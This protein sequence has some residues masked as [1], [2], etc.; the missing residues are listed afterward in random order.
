M[1]YC[2]QMERSFTSN[3]ST[4][5]ALRLGIAVPFL[6]FGIQLIAAPFFAGY[7]FLAMAASLLGSERSSLP[8]VF[9]L[10]AMLTGVAGL[11]CAIGLILAFR[12]TK[13]PAVLAWL[14]SIAVFLCGLSS[15]WAGVFP[16]PDPRH[17]ENPF[18]IGLF[19]MPF[20]ALAT[21]WRQS[22]R[23]YFLA[24]VLLFLGLIPFM[25]G[26]IAIDRSALEGLLQRLLALSAFAP[27]GLAAHQ[28]LK[29]Q[30][31]VDSTANVF[32][33]E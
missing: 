6:Y 17:A 28:L 16:M 21:F 12:M 24:C 5:T 11:V 9:N 32:K 8:V 29:L 7:D 4:I 22:Q 33:P 3:H 20:V 25:S 13:T 30:D 2:F 18:A 26:L 10:G 23:I 19:V 27:I 15:V 1:K 14:T 31:S